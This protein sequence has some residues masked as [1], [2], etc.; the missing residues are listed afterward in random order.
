MCNNCSNSNDS[1][2]S[3]NS[4]LSNSSSSEG[5][6]SLT[7]RRQ[8]NNDSQSPSSS[9]S[10]SSSAATRLQ[11]HSQEVSSPMYNNANAERIGFFTAAASAHIDNIDQIMQGHEILFGS[12]REQRDDE[13]EDD[14]MFN[15]DPLAQFILQTM[16]PSV[17]RINGYGTG[18]GLQLFDPQFTG[19][20]FASLFFGISGAADALLLDPLQQPPIDVRRPDQLVC[21]TC[22]VVHLPV[23]GTERIAIIPTKVQEEDETGNGSAAYITDGD[24][25]ISMPPLED[26]NDNKE[27]VDFSDESSSESSSSSMPP[28]EE[29]DDDV[30]NSDTVPLNNIDISTKN[31]EE[32]T[33]ETNDE[34]NETHQD[35]A[36]EEEGDSDESSLLR[37]DIEVEVVQ[38]EDEL[39]ETSSLSMPPFV[40]HERERDASSSTGQFGGY[41]NNNT[42]VNGREPEVPPFLRYLMERTNPGRTHQTTSSRNNNNDNHHHGPSNPLTHLRDYGAVRV[43]ATAT[44][45]VC[46]DEHNPVLAL[47]CGHCICEHD[48]EQLGGYLGSDKSTRSNS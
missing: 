5:M 17:G 30:K 12:G 43:F 27:E 40:E 31:D 29:L 46:L 25:S 42:N 34:E 28:L 26:M 22:M 14:A 21:P 3:D 7:S 38:E 20:L 11:Q 19:Q 10:N 8:P 6:P 45:P 18:T 44:C 9:D 13:E 1:V 37:R 35:N 24:D 33:N 48:Y 39:S 41:G 47:K 36:D 2:S 16:M 15:N 23:E 32:S 4:S